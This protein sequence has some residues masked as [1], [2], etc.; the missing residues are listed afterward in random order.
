MRS[1]SQADTLSVFLELL[2]HKKDW[3]RLGVRQ[4]CFNISS[5]TMAKLLNL[6]IL[7]W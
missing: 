6:S 1:A 3:L 7:I 4:N 2:G 5:A